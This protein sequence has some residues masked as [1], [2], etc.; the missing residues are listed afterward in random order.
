MLTNT[1]IIYWYA[2][3][4]AQGGIIM[5][6][7]LVCQIRRCIEEKIQGGGKTPI[8]FPFGDVGMQVKH[9]KR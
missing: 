8:I 1:E 5:K 6:E 2:C 4:G 9:V 7:T 3:S